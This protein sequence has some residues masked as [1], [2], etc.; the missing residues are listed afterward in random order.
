MYILTTEDL[1]E[2]RQVGEDGEPVRYRAGSHVLGVEESWNPEMLLG[3]PEGQLVVPV[4]VVLVQASEIAEKSRLVF[5][6]QFIAL[7][8]LSGENLF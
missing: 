7:Y 4:N 8:I 1:V 2:L 3:C 6:I 5:I